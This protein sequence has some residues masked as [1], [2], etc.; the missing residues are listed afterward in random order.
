MP[1]HPGKKGGRISPDNRGA[2][3]KGVGKNSK[4]HDLERQATP[5]LHG[6]SLQK[7]DVQALEQGQRV[8]PIQEQERG[9]A[10][11]PQGGGQP[12]QAGGQGVQVPDPIDFLAGKNGDQFGPPTPQRRIDES[13]AKTWLPL[14]RHLVN[15][16]GASPALVNAF[17]NQARL[18]Q[19]AGSQPATIV[20]MN[21]T[22]D[23]IEEMLNQG[24]R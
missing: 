7:G 10:P 11:Q 9:Q 15:G 6:S 8:A 5:G 14:I 1:Q 3:A 2:Q 21:A 13:R 17:I 12:Q 19:Q 24:I 22:D 23:G 4:R 18:M 20:D 16:P